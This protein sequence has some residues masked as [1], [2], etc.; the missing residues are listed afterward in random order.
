MEPTRHKPPYIKHFLDEVD[1]LRADVEA[2]RQSLAEHMASLKAEVE[3]H[4][5]VTSDF[6]EPASVS[7]M[8]SA[9]V[10]S[11]LAQR[12]DTLRREVEFLPC[13]GVEDAPTP[14]RKKR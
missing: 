14:T 9:N 1:T 11:S 3:S 5:W 8:K 2:Y 7:L 6:V 10:V 13:E 12:V 4:L